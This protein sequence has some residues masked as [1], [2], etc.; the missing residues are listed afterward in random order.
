MPVVEMTIEERINDITRECTKQGLGLVMEYD[1]VE[2][3]WTGYFD[4]S[5]EVKGTLDE[6]IDGLESELNL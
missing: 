1:P 3:L 6:V 2:E 5:P 4:D